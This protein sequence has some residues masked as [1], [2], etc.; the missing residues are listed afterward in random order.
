M[1]AVAFFICLR[2]KKEESFNKSNRE[3]VYCMTIEINDKKGNIGI[4]NI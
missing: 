3:K 2:R 4:N 1:N